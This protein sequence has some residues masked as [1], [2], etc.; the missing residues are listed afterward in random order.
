MVKNYIFVNIKRPHIRCE[1]EKATKNTVS[2]AEKGVIRVNVENVSY[3]SCSIN[4]AIADSD[5]KG[6]REGCDPQGCG[7]TLPQ[8][9][10]SVIIL[11]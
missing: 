8:R 11:L 1:S 2:H 10:N 7:G 3:I 5:P 4:Y 6:P 9:I